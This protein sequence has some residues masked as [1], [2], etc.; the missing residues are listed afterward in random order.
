MS[1]WQTRAITFS[2]P[3]FYTTAREDVTIALDMTALLIDADPPT[4]PQCVLIRQDTK[5]T[6]TLQDTPT[7]STN[8]VLQRL[9]GL[10]EG[11]LY[12][13]YVS[14]LTSGQRRE[15][16]INVDVADD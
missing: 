2:P 4:L 3:V 13:L 1:S 12:K 5:A 14:V 9:R 8:S 10:S 16:E 15:G 11:V 6:V 7:I